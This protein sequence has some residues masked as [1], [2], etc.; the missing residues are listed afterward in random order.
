MFPHFPQSTNL[1]VVPTNGGICY[2]SHLSRL[3]FFRFMIIRL[4]I[5]LEEVII[6]VCHVCALFGS[7]GPV[8]RRP[9]QRQLQRLSKWNWTRSPRPTPPPEWR[10]GQ[11][12]WAS[13]TD[14][15]ERTG[16][17]ETYETLRHWYF[18]SLIIF[19]LIFF[20]FFFIF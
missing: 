15:E 7:V 8:S 13:S 3:F 14:H 16:R 1:Y 9:R 6:I 18:F 12:R 11:W 20:Y 2:K 5:R 10:H 4:V 19:F 17:A